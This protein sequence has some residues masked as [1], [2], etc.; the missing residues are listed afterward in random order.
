MSS[1]SSD[2][3]LDLSPEN[4][5]TEGNFY[6]TVDQLIMATN[7]VYRQLSWLY[8]STTIPAFYGEL[9]SDNAYVYMTSG[10]GGSHNFIPSFNLNSGHLSWDG[11]YNSVFICNNIIEIL[12]NTEVSIAADLKL[13]LIAE[14]TLVRSFFYFNMVRVW[15]GVPLITKKISVEESYEQLRE[16]PDK[17]Y[18]QIITDLNFAKNTL[19]E[20]YSNNDVGRVTRYAAAAILAKVY[21]TIGNKAEAKNELEFIINSNRFSLDAN[22]DGSVNMDDFRHLFAAKTKNSKAS[23][24]EAQYMSG[25]NAFNSKHQPDY[26]PFY[27]E[28]HLPGYTLTR[29]GNGLMTPTDDLIS[30]FEDGDPRLEA[31]IEMGFVNLATGE[32]IYYP[33]PKKFYDPDIENPG[34]NFEIIRY[35]DILL[36]YAEVTD[37]PTY[38]N[39]VRER[40]GMPLFGTDDYPSD[41]Y[42]TLDLAIEHERRVELALEFHRFFDLVRTGRAIEV[43][44]SKGYQR[45]NNDRLLWPIPQNAIDVNPNLVQNP[46]Y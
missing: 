19:P 10:G 9:Q 45:I 8:D 29:R 17:I 33:Y 39:M 14:A 21:L 7:D 11:Y 5:I 43:M 25:V 34:Q 2:T 46:G 16:S 35:A 1:C 3:Y 37:D 41:L 36:M 20:A 4:S 32:F 40:A 26:T 38:L 42:P 44:Q 28:F 30:E 13:R 15:G 6:E 31:S 18:K 23:I 22:N 12:E 24:L 27:Q